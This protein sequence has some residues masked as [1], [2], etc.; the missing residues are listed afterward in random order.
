MM[1]SVYLINQTRI[2]EIFFFGPLD[3]SGGAKFAVSALKP[4]RGA[5]GAWCRDVALAILAT[6]SLIYEIMISEPNGLLKFIQFTISAFNQYL[7][8]S[9]AST[10]SDPRQ[11][12]SSVISYSLLANENN[13]NTYSEFYFTT[14]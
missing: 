12:R 13:K 2:W 6:K 14:T 7:W 9:D 5:S 11:F 10:T 4:K 8:I 1:W 3:F